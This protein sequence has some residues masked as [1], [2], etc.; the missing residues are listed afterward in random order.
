[1]LPLK[2]HALAL[3]AAPVLLSLWLA[4]CGDDETGPNR[5][6]CEF[7]IVTRSVR[8]DEF[9]R[10]R[11]FK[12]NSGLEEP[13]LDDERQRIDPGTI[14]VFRRMSPGPFE[15][16]DLAFLAAY[17]DSNG[18]WSGIDFQEP[19]AYAARWRELSFTLLLD[20]AGRV[21]ALDLGAAPVLDADLLGVV[22]AVIDQ[23]GEV[24]Y[25]VGDSP[26][27]GPPTREISGVPGQLYYAVKLLKAPSARAAQVS[28]A[29]EVRNFYDLG[30]R[31]I[32]PDATTVRIEARAPGATDPSRDDQGMAY[33]RIFGL[34]RE[35]G[36]GRP[37][38][39]GV[40]DSHNGEIFDL[41]NGLLRFPWDFPRPFA[42]S[43]E[44]YAACVND[45]AWVWNPASFLAGH[46]A[47]E[48]YSPLTDPGDLP[49]YGWFRIVVET[50]I[51]VVR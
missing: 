21:R 44:Q 5:P 24:A 40:W 31:S 35:D 9:V 28:F 6:E 4:G 48:L 8:S 19:F 10:N 42:G 30:G 3:A 39:D 50:R 26:A 32:D 47:P 46:L 14:Q 27:L 43:A 45:A 23:G 17:P 51:P 20:A 12:L 15:P 16:G 25:R 41:P 1:M 11:F 33:L 37:V 2:Q 34:D 18:D 7:E 22:Y 38:P 29:Y 13:G 36:A 49:V